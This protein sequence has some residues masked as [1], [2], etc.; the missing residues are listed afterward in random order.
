MV[1]MEAACLFRHNNAKHAGIPATGKAG[2]GL[3]LFHFEPRRSAKA[4]RGPSYNKQKIRKVIKLEL[5]QYMY[6]ATDEHVDTETTCNYF[7]LRGKIL[8]RVA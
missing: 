6:C 2:L 4:F 3:S 7:C 1:N 5:S 8:I